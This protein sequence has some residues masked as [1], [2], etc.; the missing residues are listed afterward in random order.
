MAGMV[1]ALRASKTGLPLAE[2]SRGATRG[3]RI[4]RLMNRLVVAEIA[5][6]LVLMIGAG[7]LVRSFDWLLDN[8][9]GFQPE[10]RLA[11]Q[12]WAYDDAH[13]VQ[14]DFFQRGIEEI[15]AVPGVEIVGLTTD[16]PL[17]DDQSLLSRG[18]TVRFTIDGRAARIPGDER[19]AGLAAIDGAYAGAMGIAL[20]DGRN[21]STLD[22]SKSPAVMM[23][24]EAFVRRHLF[25]R[26]AVG[27]RITLQWG[28]SVSREI[29][30]VLADVRRQGFASEPRPE[31]YVPLS[32]EPSNGLTFVVKTSADPATLTRAVQQA[33]WAADPRQAT[34]AIRPMTD[35]LWDWMRQRRFNTT[36]LVAFASLALFLAGIGVYGLM[37]F[38]VE[39]RTNEL[40]IRRALGGQAQDILAMVLRRTLTLALAGAG[41]GLMGSVALTRLLQGM[42]VDIQPFDPLTF[43]AVSVFVISVALLAAFFP[44]LRAT[45]IDP[46]VALRTE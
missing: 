41:L 5:L 46:M 45:R 30:G 11:A 20:R 22:H 32:Q 27:Q 29:V 42:L 21:F 34:W 6:S 13:Q 44:A 14:L 3:P 35:L 37:S 12:V 18:A 31:V 19:V 9:L 39:Q 7:L 33:L 16:L 24:N 25:D 8:G 38:S 17:A 40:G 10:G 43:G 2:G 36:L 1:P 23:V 15:S 26:D 4:G 28:T